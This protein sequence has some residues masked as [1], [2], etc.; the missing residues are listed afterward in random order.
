[1]RK[2]QF[3]GAAIPNPGPMGI[4]VVLFEND[5][6]IEQI[7]EKL[8][9]VG[10]NNVAE[11]SALTRGLQRAFNLNW[12]DIIV[13]GDSLLVVKQI[14]GEWKV[15]KDSLKLLHSHA[16][17]LMKQFNS[18]KIVKIPG[19]IN[20]LADHLACKALGFDED[21]YHFQKQHF[22]GF[23]SKIKE[24]MNNDLDIKCPE[25]HAECTFQ[26]QVFKDGT[27]HIRQRCPRCNKVRY[28]PQTDFIKQLADKE[29][30]KQQT[31]F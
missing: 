29:M 5:N 4:G 8:T 7:S 14:N 9:E 26:W 16:K 2:I 30:E 28:A 22:H 1:M 25:C 12:N 17:E 20:S 18:V 13:E 31:L 23:P 27:R 3:D 19:E 6:V 15:K 10:T 24:D 11:Y 21:P